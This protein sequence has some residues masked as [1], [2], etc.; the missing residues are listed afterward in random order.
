MESTKDF[1]AV[2]AGLKKFVRLIPLRQEP[3]E[4]KY[5]QDE[6]DLLDALD[7][8]RTKFLE[9]AEMFGKKKY[10]NTPFNF[11]EDVKE[12]MEEW[13]LNGRDTTQASV[14]RKMYQPMYHLVLV[15]VIDL[16]AN[17][18]HADALRHL[19]TVMTDVNNIV[20][21][22][23]ISGTLDDAKVMQAIIHK[24]I[25]QKEELRKARKTRRT[26]KQDLFELIVEELAFE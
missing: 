19:G 5:I 3:M 20:Q 13:L 16:F 6:F 24:E 7:V 8:V 10:R 14:R 11:V 26:K 17:D 15:P 2:E 23:E 4:A 22:H 21:N 18:T 12:E 9:T 1:T 25:R